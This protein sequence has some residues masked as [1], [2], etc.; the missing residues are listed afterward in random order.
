MN[1]WKEEILDSQSLDSGPLEAKKQ[2]RLQPSNQSIKSIK[3]SVD[4]GAKRQLYNNSYR[5]Y[6]R[7]RFGLAALASGDAR[8]A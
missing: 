3:Q 4:P 2:W 7:R 6:M 8:P 1:G 5:E